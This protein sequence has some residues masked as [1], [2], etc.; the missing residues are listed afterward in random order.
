[1]TDDEL[2]ELIGRTAEIANSNARAIAALSGE[3]SQLTRSQQQFQESMESS[4][5]DLTEMLAQQADE[6]ARDRAELR[7]LIE[8]M[9][10]NGG[11]GNGAQHE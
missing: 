8:Q 1:M 6:A 7:R 9:Y 11:N 2:R 10:G 3:V 4:I 5:S